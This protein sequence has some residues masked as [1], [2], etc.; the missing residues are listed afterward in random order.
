M[1]ICVFF[2]VVL[3]CVVAC[4]STYSPRLSETDKQQK[5]TLLSHIKKDDEFRQYIDI[6]FVKSCEDLQKYIVPR[7]IEIV[8]I[9]S[10]KTKVKLPSGRTIDISSSSYSCEGSNVI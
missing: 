4:K 1:R 2:V 10:K 5:K 3:S 8:S 9:S 7:G 6:M